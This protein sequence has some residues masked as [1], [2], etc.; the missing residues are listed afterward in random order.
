MEMTPEIRKAWADL[1][2]AQAAKRAANEHRDAEVR[3]AKDEINARWADRLRAVHDAVYDA[4]LALEAAKLA[5]PRHPWEGQKVG[6]MSVVRSGSG[7]TRSY[8]RKLLYGIVE[9]RT[10]QTEF[11]ENVSYWRL[12]DIGQPFVRLLKADGEPGKK[13]A[14]GLAGWKLAEEITEQTV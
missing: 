13:F 1:E 6:K 9:T 7:W 3:A 4:S 10:P 2:A 5:A 12:P 8:E 11:P 14:M